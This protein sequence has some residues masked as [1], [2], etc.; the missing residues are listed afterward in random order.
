QS[1]NSELL[2]LINKFPLDI[3]ENQIELDEYINLDNY[4]AANEMPS[5]KSIIET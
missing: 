2:I 4:I 3:E 1:T 5:M